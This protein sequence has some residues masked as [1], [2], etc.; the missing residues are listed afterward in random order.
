MK[1]FDGDVVTFVLCKAPKAYIINYVSWEQAMYNYHSCENFY[2]LIPVRFA[3][4]KTDLILASNK[5]LQQK[6]PVN[7]WKAILQ[8]SGG[9]LETL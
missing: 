6:S 3:S 1:E 4:G 9:T 5:Y 7:Q 8:V 2:I